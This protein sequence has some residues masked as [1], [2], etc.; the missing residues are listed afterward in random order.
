MNQKLQFSLL[1]SALLALPLTSA[2]AGPHQDEP[3]VPGESRE[4]CNKTSPIN[5]DV[6]IVNGVDGDTLTVRASDGKI[7]NVRM[8]GMDTPETH[9]MGQSQG[10]W[11]D[12]AA[13]R[14]KQFLPAGSRARLEFAPSICDTYDRYLAHVFTPGKM[15]VNLR[16]AQEGLAVLYCLY[17]SVKYCETIGAATRAAIQYRKGMFTDSNVELPYDFRRRIAGREQGSLTGNMRTKEVFRPGFQERVP[18]GDRI[19]LQASEPLPPGYR[20]AK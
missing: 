17:P 2:F 3:P 14:L 8:I 19:F 4:K 20:M 1:L 10:K 11:G 9:Y 18:P 16:M 12:A 13:A 6:T 15:H 7:Y 5:P